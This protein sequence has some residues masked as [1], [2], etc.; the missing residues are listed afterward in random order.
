M[1]KCFIAIYNDSII[2]TIWLL[3][4]NGRVYNW[5]AGSQRE[6]LNKSPNDLLVWNAIQWGIENRYKIFDFG[7]AGKPGEKY[8]VRDFKKK[9][10]GKEV[11]FGR[12]EQIH[13][14]LTYSTMMK[15]F[16]IKKSIGL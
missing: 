8:G 7:G 10:G 5:Y 13:R 15:L 16:S 3:A 11:C 4:Y 14:P 1:V 12:F 9:F 6:Q 2:G